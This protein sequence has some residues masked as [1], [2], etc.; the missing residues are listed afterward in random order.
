MKTKSRKT[1]AAGDHIKATRTGKQ[2]ASRERIVN[3]DQDSLSLH[4]LDLSSQAFT[5]FDI[6]QLL[7][8]IH[9]FR[10]EIWSPWAILLVRFR[11]DTGPSPSLN[12]YRQLFT[13]QGSGTLNMVDFFYDMSHGKLD[14]SGSQVFGWYTLAANRSDYVGNVYP[15]PAG[16]L[17]RNGLL[18]LAKSTAAANGVNLAAYAGVV[19]SGLGAVDLCGWIGGMAALCDEN[20]LTPSLMG[21]EMGHGYGLDH[22]RLQGSTD[23]YQDPYDVM[24]TAAFPGMQTPHREFDTAGPGLNSW[25]MRSRGWLDENRVWSSPSGAWNV[26]LQ[27]RPLH[28]KDL[29]GILAAQIGPYLVE[30]RMPERWDAAFPN[31]CV[32]VHRFDDNHSYLMPATS[33]SQHLQV[34][35]QFRVGDPS[36]SLIDY[37]A[38]DVTEIDTE[39][40]TATIHVYQRR[41]EHPRVTE[42]IFAQVFGG[43]AVDGGGFIIV[44]GRIIP[45]PPRGP[46]Y[47]LVEQ[48]VRY[49]EVGTGTTGVDTSRTAKRQ[50]LAEVVR[51]AIQLHAD[52]AAVSEQPPGYS[53][54]SQHG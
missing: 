2:R 37:F 52:A 23:D 11:D 34:G 41:G 25:N 12:K 35:S 33:G 43:I 31:A 8:S 53:K 22:A 21:Q 16:K 3:Q 13:S 50:A 49:L 6:S 46:A 7:D 42:G 1:S 44:N 29:P 36:I 28:R 9:L 5:R 45:I 38:I 26:T 39:Q 17:N 15:Q 27:L 4:T 19:V 10:G 40:Q 24:S 48:V 54:E 51:A 30:F 20:S 18:D 47:D 14:I 32:L